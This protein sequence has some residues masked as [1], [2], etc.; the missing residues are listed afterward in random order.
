M[1]LKAEPQR[2][3]A[4]D[5]H[6]SATTEA[7]GDYNMPEDAIEESDKR[8][9]DGDCAIIEDLSKSYGQSVND[10]RKHSKM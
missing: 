3:D 4:G 2:F 9:L 6:L 1:P 10:W 5:V 7:L 8:H